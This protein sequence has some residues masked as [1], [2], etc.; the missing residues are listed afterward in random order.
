MQK[1]NLNWSELGFGYIKTACHL[2]YYFKNGS[3]D[4]GKVVND[5]NITIGIASTSLHYGQQCFEGLKAFTHKDGSIRIFRVD[6][7]AK[8]MK[9]SAEKIL[10][11]AFPEKEFINAIIKLIQLN[12]QFVPPYGSGACLYIRPLMIG[13]SN[14][15]G[16]RPSDE[17]LFMV[18]C[19]PVGPYFK[20]GMKPIRLIVEE[21]MDRAAPDGVGDVKVGGNYAASLRA[22]KKAYDLGYPAV[23]Y[24]D[25]KEK[26]YID[27]SGPAN[28]FGVTKDNIYVTPKSE[29]IL[30]SITN[31]SLM[32]LAEDMGIKVEQ[33]PIHIDEIGNFVEAGC[34]GTAAVITPVKSI[35][36]R[37]NEIVYAKS[38]EVGEISKKLYSL[39]TAIQTGDSE[40]KFGWNTLVEMD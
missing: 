14:I 24:L 7:N 30:A 38:D 16:V 40:D 28:F 2:E 19:T 27:E 12:N 3:W 33:R 32:T 18:F 22:A 13:I 8:R 39:L 1:V 5:D 10:M 37:Q 23:L 31:K 34:C 20:T 6:E 36:Y 11:P 21:K 15:I 17:Y 29:S 26:K 25:P 9:K 35:T 4:S